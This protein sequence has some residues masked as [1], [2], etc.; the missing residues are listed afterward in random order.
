DIWFDKDEVE[1]SS[2]CWLSQRLETLEKCRA[3]I[4]FL[5]QNYFRCSVA[6]LETKIL[7]E[8]L[9]SSEKS[10]KVFPVLFSPVEIPKDLSMLFEGAIDLTGAYLANM[11][12]SE[13]SSI[14]IGNLSV[15][16]DQY[17]LIRAPFHPAAPPSSEFTGEFK[18]KKLCKWSLEDVQE[19]LH[20]K[21][22]REFYRQ[23]FAEAM[24][25]GFL[26]S[27]LT[28]EALSQYL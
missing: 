28:D 12:L 24:I 26:L 11:S 2:S 23:T 14:V 15:E 4:I 7:L 6:L 13:K 25:D 20:H 19:W 1:M 9:K 27:S 10:V 16:I 18:S 22:I 21:G 5:S 17:S 8:R 3:A